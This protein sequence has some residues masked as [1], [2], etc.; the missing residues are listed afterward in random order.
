LP[1]PPVEAPTP[2]DQ[3]AVVVAVANNGSGTPSAPTTTEPPGGYSAEVACEGFVKG[4]LK[5]PTMAQ[6]SSEAFT[7]KRP[8]FTVTGDVDAQNSFGAMLGNHWTCVVKLDG[9]SWVL[10]SLTG[11]E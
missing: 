5:A 10:Q 6:F 1:D 2:E 9:D 7:G 11:I 8:T 4:E 3:H